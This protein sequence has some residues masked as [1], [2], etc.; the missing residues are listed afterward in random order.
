MVK[1]GQ[2]ILWFQVFP[3]SVARTQECA[4]TQTLRADEGSP[5]LSGGVIKNSPSNCISTQLRLKCQEVIL[6]S[7]NLPFAFCN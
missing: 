5:I 6:L 7:Y 4:W 2:S 1:L 3:C